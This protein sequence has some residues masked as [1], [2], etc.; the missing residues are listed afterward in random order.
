[1]K[2]LVAVSLVAHV[3]QLELVNPLLL[4]LETHLLLARS[5]YGYACTPLQ[6]RTQVW[7]ASSV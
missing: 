5:R 4:Q 2:Y 6:L 1:M 3:L 7:L